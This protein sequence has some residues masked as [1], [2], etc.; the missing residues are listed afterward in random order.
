MSLNTNIRAQVRSLLSQGYKIGLEY[1]DKRRFKTSSWLSAGFING[2]RKEQVSQSLEASL[3]NL[4]GEYV[5]LIGVESAA[6][7]RVLEMIIQRP[8]DTPG[9]RT[10]PP[11][12]STPVI[13][14]VT[15]ILTC[16]YKCVPC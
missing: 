5:R 15:A 2:S 14:T 3:R 13:A 7:R 10:A 12:P 1:A 8:E 9:N 11:P 4:Q 16:R 6:K